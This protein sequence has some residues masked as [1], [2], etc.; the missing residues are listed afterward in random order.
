MTFDDDLARLQKIGVAGYDHVLVPFALY[1]QL[2]HERKELAERK[3]HSDIILGRS[4]KGVLDRNPE[5][6][7]FFMQSIG[8][9]PVES[10][11]KKSKRK[12][13]LARTP[14]RSAVYR[15]WERVRKTYK[16]DQ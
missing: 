11:I 5:V 12:F 1:V 14:S 13:G 3:A 4:G 7:F 6:A 15:Y 16:I 2:M 10:L 9:C 8:T